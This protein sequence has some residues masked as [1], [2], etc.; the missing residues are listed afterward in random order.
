VANSSRSALLKKWRKWKASHPDFPLTVNGNGCWSKA[1]RGQTHYFGRLDEPDD[2]LELWLL[3]KDYL[4]AG[5]EPPDPGNPA[6]TVKDLVDEFKQDTEQRRDRGEIGKEN[7]RDLLYAANFVVQHLPQMR[8]VKALTPKHFSALRDAV[9][10]KTARNLRSQKNLIGQI[11]S[12]FH[13]GAETDKGM[14]FYAPVRFGPRFCAP[15]ADSLRKEKEASGRE[16]YIDEEGL[17]ALLKLAKPAMKCMI[18]LGV[19]CGF[20]AIDSIRITFSRLHLDAEIPYHNF[21]RVKNGL[22][23]KAVLWPETVAAL[24]SYVEKHRGDDPSDYVILN[25]Y[26]RPYTDAATGRGIRRA[27]ENLLTAAEVTVSP[28]TSIGSLR[29]V[30]GTVVEYSHDQKMIDLSMGHVSK[31]IQKEIYVQRNLSEL[32]RLQELAEIVRE[33]LF[34]DAPEEDDGDGETPATIPFPKVG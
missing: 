20:Y 18:L 31:A 11:R 24:K 7:A 21:P 6:F 32:D 29:H 1:V 27:F 12:I 26:G 2:A 33:W 19:N 3:Q 17:R 22:P 14:G 30:Y 13:W 28:G 4:L 5:Q 25:Q 23:R 34:G 15:S 8:A 10:T 9:A 16:R